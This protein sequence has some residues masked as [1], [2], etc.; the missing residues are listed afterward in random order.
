MNEY[1]PYEAA[2]YLHIDLELYLTYL[3]SGKI[4]YK[5]QNCSR[6]T[7]EKELDRFAREVLK[8][9]L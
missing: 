8:T 9:C 4:C 7:T 2:N 6:V 1:R 3:N 5:L